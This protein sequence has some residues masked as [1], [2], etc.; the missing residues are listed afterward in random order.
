MIDTHNPKLSLGGPQLWGSII[1]T[2]ARFYTL[3]QATPT[4]KKL[5]ISEIMSKTILYLYL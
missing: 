5:M 2:Q 3:F 4:P 1:L